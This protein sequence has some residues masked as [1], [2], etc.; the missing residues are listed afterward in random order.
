MLN[1]LIP[2]VQRLRSRF[3]RLHAFLL[4]LGRRF[5]GGRLGVYPRVMGDEISAVASVLRSGQ[6]NM[7]SGKWLTHERLE[8]SFAE[9]V[10]A[11]HAIAVNTGGM[12]LQMSIRALGL[13]PGDE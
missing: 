8:A 4:F 6:W 3:P 7:T 9:F 12:A 10:G 13:K 1:A 5:L 11:K 2:Y